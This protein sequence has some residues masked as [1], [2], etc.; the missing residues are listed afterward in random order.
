LDGTKIAKLYTPEGFDLLNRPNI[1]HNRGYRLERIAK[2]IHLINISW[3]SLQVEG[4]QSIQSPEG[5]FR[6]ANLNL[7]KSKSSDIYGK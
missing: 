2:K 3:A 4:Q 1:P 6:E 7:M 5:T